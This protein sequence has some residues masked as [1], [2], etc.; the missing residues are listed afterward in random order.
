MPHSA[1]WTTLSGCNRCRRLQG[2]GASGTHTS[3]A[4]MD[5]QTERTL[6]SFRDALV[7]QLGDELGSMILFG[8]GTGSHYLDEVSDL[9]LLIVLET[10][11]M[12]A[13]ETTRSALRDHKQIAVDP[14]IVTRGELER[15]PEAFPIE[16]A[17]MQAAHRVLSGEDVLRGLNVRSEAIREQLVA[18]VLGKTMRLRTVFAHAKRGDAKQLRAL[19]IQA[20]GPFAALMRAALHVGDAH[21]AEFAPP[22]EFL[23]ILAQMEERFGM[24]LEGFR[25]ASLIK[26]GDETP[27]GVELAAIFEKVLTEAEGLRTLVESIRSEAA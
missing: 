2:G 1:Y 15:L 16:T 3:M 4:T 19:L 14:V 10:A 11:S 24:E 23:E 20:I 17:D 8:S 21:F 22:R 12:S 26:S 9:N 5:A 25:S 7:E 6:T 27:D 13:L 18:E